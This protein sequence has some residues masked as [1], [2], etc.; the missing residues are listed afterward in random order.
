MRENRLRKKLSEQRILTG[1]LVGMPTPSL[2][3][4]IGYLGFD[5]ILLDGEH[6]PL[7]AKDVEEFGR[8]AAAADVP[9]LARVGANRH[10]LISAFADAGAD[11]VLVPH[12]ATV[13]QAEA[14][15][16]AVRFP[17]YGT[18][19]LHGGT[20]GAGFGVGL[21][22][23]KYFGDPTAGTV[24]AVMIEDKE[25]LDHLDDLAQ[26]DGLDVYFVGPS[27]LAGSL[28]HAGDLEHP[29]VRDALRLALT[30]L[31]K[32]ETNAVAF[33]AHNP[34]QI[35]D[36][37]DMGVRMIHTSTTRQ[38]VATLRGYLDGARRVADEKS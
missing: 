23:G 33:L 12:V 8:A 7:D 21:D 32:V 38:F 25:A 22:T 36:A 5:W 16:S 30:T 20:R 17:P 6:E 1:A 13:E 18:R 2:V 26:V 24:P 3:E 35:A 11:G 9:L 15:V 4:L 28:G 27:D 37:I 19:G 29:E 14:V 34:E 31:S 10:E